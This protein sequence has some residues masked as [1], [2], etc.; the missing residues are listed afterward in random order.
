[1][2]KKT[3]IQHYGEQSYDEFLKKCR[4]G[5]KRKKNGFPSYKPVNNVTVKVKTKGNMDIL[6]IDRL[7]EQQKIASRLQKY[8][9]CWWKKQTDRKFILI[10]DYGNIDKSNN[11]LSYKI[12]LTQLD[13]KEEEIRVFQEG[14]VKETEEYLKIIEI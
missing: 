2:D 6:L 5:K 14:V 9:T 7:E 3:Y 11:I 4:A 1:M 10:V 12:E 13:L 8:L